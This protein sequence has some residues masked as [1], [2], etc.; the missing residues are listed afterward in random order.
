M[1]QV[2]YQNIEKLGVRLD[3]NELLLLQEY[4]KIRKFRKNQYIVQQGDVVRYETFVVKGITRTY[5]V[6]DREQEHV[7]AFSPEGWWVGDLYS[8]FTDNSTTYN[9]DCLEE[10]TVLQITRDGLEKLCVNVPKL[11]CYYRDLYRNS[12]IANIK[13]LQS[14]LEKTALERYQEF[15]EKYPQVEQRVPNHQI[16]AF[17]GITP[18]SLSRIRRLS[19]KPK[20]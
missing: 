18:Q 15:Q 11:N 3:A 2:L 19:V 17:L 4:F 16:A 5:T 20:N 13:R 1:W 10:T 12:V 6:D 7:I 14:T 9:I 8:F